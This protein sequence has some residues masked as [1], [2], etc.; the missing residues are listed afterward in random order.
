MAQQK[1]EALYQPQGYSYPVSV[2]LRLIWSKLETKL[3]VQVDTEL[4]KT[5]KPCAS[6]VASALNNTAV[7]S[8]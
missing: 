5:D 1:G 4:L 2:E 6:L 3:L 7:G 8:S